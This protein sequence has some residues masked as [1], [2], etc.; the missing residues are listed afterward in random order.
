MA[1]VAHLVPMWELKA[2][3]SFDTLD[4]SVA[5]AVRLHLQV[6]IPITPSQLLA[7]LQRKE[8]IWL[9]TQK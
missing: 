9:G 1:M 2:C 3:S 6:A 8:Q 7:H 5:L 4:L